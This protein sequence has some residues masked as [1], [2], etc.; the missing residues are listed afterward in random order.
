MSTG[1]AIREISIAGR[2]FAVPADNDVTKRLGGRQ[3]E[4]QPNGDGISGRYIETPTG[5]TLDGVQVSI[6]ENKGDGDFL[7]GIQGGTNPTKRDDAYDVTITEASGHTRQGRGRITGELNFSTQN[8]TATFTMM[9]P[10]SLA[11]Q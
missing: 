8:A 10:G 3:V 11:L 4:F 1:G 9:G 2:I 7:K 5:W 6:D